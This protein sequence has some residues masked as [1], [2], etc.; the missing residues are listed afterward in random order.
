MT[1]TTTTT[2]TITTYTTT[3][4]VESDDHIHKGCGDFTYLCSVDANGEKMEPYVLDFS[5]MPPGITEDEKSERTI[6]SMGCLDKEPTELTTIHYYPSQ[7]TFIIYEDDEIVKIVWTVTCWSD[8]EIV[9][10]FEKGV[11]VNQ[12]ERYHGCRELNTK[13]K[14]GKVSSF[15]FRGD[16]FG[17]PDEDGP[18]LEYLLEIL[19]N[20]R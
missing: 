4:F 7:N 12:L 16:E 20:K 14:D 5:V 3:V 6:A 13:Y 15:S 8:D 10:T 9:Y 11:L 2:T 19:T 17:D 1:T 18:T